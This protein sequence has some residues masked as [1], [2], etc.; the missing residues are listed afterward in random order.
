MILCDSRIEY[1]VKINHSYGGSG[2]KGRTR[3]RN[4]NVLKGKKFIDFSSY[5]LPAG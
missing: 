1:N 2:K 3:E 5:L 4:E